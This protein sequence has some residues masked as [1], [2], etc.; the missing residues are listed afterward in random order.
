MVFF[1]RGW[2]EKHNNGVNMLKFNCSKELFLIWFLGIISL[3]TGVGQETQIRGFVDTQFGM[4]RSDSSTNGKNN[5]GFALGM[6]DLYFTSQINEKFTF[7]GEIVFEWDNPHKEWH[8][9]VERIIIQYSTRDYL[10]I[11]AGKFHTPFG[12]WNNAYHHGALIQPTINRPVIV[13]FEDTGGF[14]PVHQLGFQVG[15]SAISKRNFG[16]N[17]LISNGHSQ[18]NTG[19]AFDYS[20]FAISGNISLEPIEGLQFLASGYTTRVPKNSTT[21]Q[22]I[23]LLNDSRYT[24]F[25]G[26]IS[27]LRPTAPIE[28]IVEYYGIN[29][30]MLVSKTTNSLY[31]Y[32]GFPINK[33]F[34]PYVLYNKVS[35]ETGESY[36]I[37]NNL[38]E[39]TLGARYSF[40]P[41]VI[42]K[43]EY[44]GN[45][46][47]LY[48][49]S[50]LIHF[51]FAIG[52]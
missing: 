40:S 6:F 39:I 7:L 1:V 11:S 13:R 19:G 50:N 4:L 51:Q 22:G 21:F 31:A 41:M 49:N 23:T 18:G 34:V 38:D 16:Y 44:T 46:S 14:L 12:F 9:D 33:K 45:K 25:N 42:L 2:K 29:N 10:K 32:I 52:F 48:L 30:R 24:L 20:E 37:K 43:L 26:A 15:G 28:F 5:H 36:F 17:I 27:F 8:L 3:S 47:E 35:H